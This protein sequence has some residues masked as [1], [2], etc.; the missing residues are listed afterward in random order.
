MDIYEQDHPTFSQPDN[1]NAIVWR[2]LDLQKLVWLLHT[3][4]LYFPRVDLLG[5]P[6]EG[7]VTEATL[8]EF[9]EYLKRFGAENLRD[10]LAE[11]RAS[12]RS[13]TYVNCWSIGN[14][15][16]E[17]LWRLYCGPTEG[18]A[19]K[20][21][22]QTLF[23]NVRHADDGIYVGLVSYIDYELDG[24]PHNNAFYPYMH[25]RE[26]FSHEQEVR[27]VKMSANPTGPEVA[28]GLPGISV[29]IDLPM[30][31]K[32][33]HVHPYAPAFY[34]K[35]IEAVVDSLAPSL[36]GRLDWSLMRRTPIY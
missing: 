12:L 1:A 36:T 4:K 33:I 32:A 6:H 3:S 18:V 29:P 26:A 9:E 15:E 28:K 11:A 17:A 23:D 35:S 22:Y 5:D 16:S 27:A 34:F 20:S 8:S 30:L 31:V 24:F 19:I 7:A 25:K 2:Y 14:H 13:H 21:D 10:G